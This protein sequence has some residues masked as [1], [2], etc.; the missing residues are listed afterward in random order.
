MCSQAHFP[1]GSWIGGWNGGSAC[2]HLDVLPG[3]VA[4]LVGGH[5]YG[6]ADDGLVEFGGLVDTQFGGLTG[7]HVGDKVGKLKVCDEVHQN[8]SHWNHS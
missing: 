5:V 3:C 4:D 7:G 1:S 2:G 8:R 6:W